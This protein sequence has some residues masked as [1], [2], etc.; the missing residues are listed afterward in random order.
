MAWQM[1]HPLACAICRPGRLGR[2]LRVIG[3]SHHGLGLLK[4]Y[5]S[6]LGYFLA[7]ATAYRRTL[8]DLFYPA[9]A[10]DTGRHV[11]RHGTTQRLLCGLNLCSVS[12]C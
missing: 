1:A 6:F 9:H 12:T 10:S 3:D 11:A 5:S 8:L 2:V 7:A 4:S